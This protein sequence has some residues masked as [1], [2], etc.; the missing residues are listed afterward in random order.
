MV[1]GAWKRGAEASIPM[2]R[3]PL[4][5][6][7]GTSRATPEP[8]R[9]AAGWGRD[10]RQGWEG[11]RTASHASEFL[12]RWHLLTL[13]FACRGVGISHLCFRKRKPGKRFG[14]KLS[15]CLGAVV[16][17]VGR[18]PTCFCPGVTESGSCTAQHPRGAEPRPQTRSALQP[19]WAGCVSHRIWM[20]PSYCQ[21]EYLAKEMSLFPIIED[22]A[23]RNVVAS[24][25]NK[26]HRP[27]LHPGAERKAVQGFPC[28]Q[29]SRR[30][31]WR[32]A[33]LISLTVTKVIWPSAGW[34]SDQSLYTPRTRSACCLLK[35]AVLH[36]VYAAIVIFLSLFDLAF[37]SYPPQILSHPS[38]LSHQ[39]D[40]PTGDSILLT[41]HQIH[42]QDSLGITIRFTETRHYT[43]FSSSHLSYQSVHNGKPSKT[44]GFGTN[45]VL[46]MPV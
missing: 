18:S 19:T 24:K 42:T 37:S 13:T 25:A 11:A 29:I 12:G 5:T 44:P 40:D 27:L 32:A 22:K 10:A 36:T 17:L 16:A 28:S 2:S 35:C 38:P 20:H 41:A 43:H 39:P 33:A 21:P 6:T 4:T 23:T 1:R 14:I 15:L 7:H 9:T 46:F 31:R 30:K 34:N 45:A 8:S 26:T 3:T